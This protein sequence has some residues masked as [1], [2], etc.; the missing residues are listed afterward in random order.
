MCVI[1]DKKS[2]DWGNINIDYNYIE[3][4]EIESGK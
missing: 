1:I 2:I 3:S 4:E